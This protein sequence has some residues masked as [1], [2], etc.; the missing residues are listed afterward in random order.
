MGERGLRE[1][2][3]KGMKGGNGERGVAEKKAE[4]DG[5]VGGKET[6]GYISRPIFLQ[7]PCPSI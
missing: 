1:G 2:K 4:E 6:E 3:G 5:V 7:T